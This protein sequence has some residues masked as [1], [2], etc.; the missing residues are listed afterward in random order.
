MEKAK[1]FF[2]KFV[3]DEEKEFNDCYDN[4]V[5]EK[6][7]DSFT[8]YLSGSYCDFHSNA[9]IIEQEIDSADIIY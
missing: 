9:K 1:E 8:A 6:S 4:Y 2:D 7:K 5:I 3:N